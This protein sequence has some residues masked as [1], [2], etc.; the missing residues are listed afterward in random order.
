MEKSRSVTISGFV[1]YYWIKEMSYRESSSSNKFAKFWIIC[2][3]ELEMLNKNE[4][5]L[6]NFWS[7]IYLYNPVYFK[8][9]TNEFNSNNLS[10]IYKL[11]KENK[12]DLFI[13]KFIGDNSQINFSNTNSRAK[14]HS[15]INSYFFK[16]NFSIEEF[17]E[18]SSQL[19]K[20]YKTG[21]ELGININDLH[22]DNLGRRGDELVAFDCTAPN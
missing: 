5:D 9:L 4:V 11:I 2:M 1:K 19:L 17:I 15:L 20:I 6:V 16:S 13:K 14:Y 10:L 3:E 7:R 12:I 8:K 18:F 21:F 22:G